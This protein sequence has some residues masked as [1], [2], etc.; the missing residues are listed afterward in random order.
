MQRQASHSQASGILRRSIHNVAT[1]PNHPMLVAL[2]QGLLQLPA[3]PKL[4]TTAAL[5]VAAYS[6]WLAATLQQGGLPDFLPLLL[7][8]LNA[9]ACTPCL[10]RKQS[11]G[12]NN[13]DRAQL[14]PIC[15]RVELQL[16]RLDDLS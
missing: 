11:I 8:M 1:Q 2:F 13:L 10:R 6:E 5:T 7:Q 14:A 12:L 4:Q 3:V 15:G 9:G 16:L